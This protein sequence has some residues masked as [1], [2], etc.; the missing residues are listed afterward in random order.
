M[1]GI[2]KVY[3][4]VNFFQINFFLQSILFEQLFLVILETS[5]YSF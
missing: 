1:V 5:P 2:C 3:R 4:S